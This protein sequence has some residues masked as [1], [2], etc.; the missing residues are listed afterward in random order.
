MKTILRLCFVTSI[1][2]F[3]C[4]SAYG[5]ELNNPNKL[6]PCPKIDVSATYDVGVGGRT[7][8]WTNCWGRYTVEL[9]ATHK[10]DVLEGEWLN[11]KLNGQGTYFYL[12]DNQFKG[13]KYVGEF[14]D[15]NMHGQGT[16]TWA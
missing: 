5:Q 11:G 9:S 4:G 14:K 1:F 12:A 13:D 8:K 6:A 2:A 3:V 15:G 10:G 16:Y 7:G